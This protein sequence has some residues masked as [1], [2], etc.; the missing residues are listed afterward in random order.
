[1]YVNTQI[2]FLENILPSF[3]MEEGRELRSNIHRRR[4]LDLYI[5]CHLLSLKK[6]TIYIN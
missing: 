3:E 5:R 1:M 2:N 6:I 4:E